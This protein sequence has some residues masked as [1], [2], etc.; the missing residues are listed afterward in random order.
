M[1]K[2]SSKRQTIH[3]VVY[4]RLKKAIINGEFK[5]GQRLI[6]RE[7]C[8]LLQVSRT[9]LRAAL[10]RLVVEGLL[11]N[12]AYKGII[13]P[14]LSVKE[15]KDLIDVREVIEG[16]AVKK[17][18]ENIDD[19]GL[20]KLKNTLND[21]DELLA[22]NDIKGLVKIN[23]QFHQIIAHFSENDFVIQ[24]LKRLNYRITLS[25]STSLHVPTRPEDTIKEH[26]EIYN[27]MLKGYTDLAERLM[28]THIKN[29]G[30]VAIQALE[31][32]ENSFL[33]PIERDK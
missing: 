26:Y 2:M 7:L 9:P 30:E 1:T 10:N 17:A 19:E 25:R 12:K 15:V 23:D 27:A 20:K 4:R 11:E 28:R 33:T 14:S 32:S 21:S 18:I 8:E 22:S 13:V 24:T 3:D 31:Q 5:S 6:E 16:L 29:A